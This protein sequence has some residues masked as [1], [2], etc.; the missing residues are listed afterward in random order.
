M[1]KVFLYDRVIS[2]ARV[3]EFSVLMTQHTSL[4]IL[5]TC[6]DRTQRYRYRYGKSS[7]VSK[8]V[9]FSIARL[10]LAYRTD[11][12]YVAHLSE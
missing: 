4:F 7:T 9:L 2:L 10:E 3:K 11:T 5:Q 8:S 1:S 6:F 12:Q